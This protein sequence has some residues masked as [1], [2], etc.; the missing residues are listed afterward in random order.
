MSGGGLG[1]HTPWWRGLG[2]A[3]ATSRC[4]WPLVHLLLS[5]GLRLHVR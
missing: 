2:L 5:F 3:R 4:G 1:G